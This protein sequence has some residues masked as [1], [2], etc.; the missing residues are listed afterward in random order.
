MNAEKETSTEQPEPVAYARSRK[1]DRD[2]DLFERLLL[3][4]ELEL[5]N[6]EVSAAEKSARWAMASMI[7]AVASMLITLWQ[8][9]RT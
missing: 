5:R 6:R 1:F 7:V 4:H 8:L 9:F 2:M 3:E